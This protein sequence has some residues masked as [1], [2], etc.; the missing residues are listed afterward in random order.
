MTTNREEEKRQAAQRALGY[1]EQG[2][3]IGVGTGSTVAH[4]IDALGA[5]RDRIE[6]AVSS[7]EQSTARLQQHGIRVID[8]NSA[9]ELALYIDGADECD[10]NRCLIKGGGA[11]L[12]REKIIAAA[13]KIFVCMIDSSKRVDVLGKFPLPIEVIPMARSFVAREITKRGGRP[14]WR[15]SVVTDNGNCILDVHDLKI[16]D[17]VALE[18]DLN[19][20]TGVV[21]V[22]LFARR[23]ADIVLIG[24]SVMA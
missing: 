17:P 8:L 13:S 1:V 20:I 3:I 2:S 24:N 18:A 23:P 11:A 9:G 6:A 10:P 22:G 21:C 16:T 15:E 12:T 14:V 7:S 19:Q 5:V 4:F